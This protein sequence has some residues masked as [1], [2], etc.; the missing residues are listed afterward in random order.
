MPVLPDYDTLTGT[1]TSPEPEAIAPAMFIERTFD[2]D[3]HRWRVRFSVFTDATRRTRI[4]DG[5]GEG[6]FELADPW[7]AV[8]AARAAVFYFSRRL[9]T[10]HTRELA[11]QLTEQK[12]GVTPWAPGVQQDVSH[13]G[14]LFMPSLA[15]S[16]AEYDL[17]AF[18][19]GPGNARDLYL[20]DRSHP[21][22]S[23]DH[24]PTK[25][26]PWPVRMV[27]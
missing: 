12:S 21:M 3:G 24:R 27:P 16:A 20:G 9:F 11:A 7:S 18:A 15:D 13:T 1:W 6:M 4:I 19:T 2:F 14:A 23:P 10:V 22:D 26:N 25:R 5:V 8:E 17:V